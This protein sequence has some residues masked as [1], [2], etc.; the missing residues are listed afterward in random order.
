[1]LNEVTNELLILKTII[2]SLLLFGE[3]KAILL[4]WSCSPRGR[5]LR[6]GRAGFAAD[7][8]EASVEAVHVTAGPDAQCVGSEV[9]GSTH[10]RHWLN[11]A[12]RGWQ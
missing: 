4:L 3:M 11:S 6:S 10:W 12:R 7:A 9:A 1:M 2:G 8:T 5:A